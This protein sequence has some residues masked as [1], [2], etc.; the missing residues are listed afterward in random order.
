MSMQL[1]QYDSNL[2]GI[3]SPRAAFRRRGLR[4]YRDG[5]T[6]AWNPHGHARRGKLRRVYVI[7]QSMRQRCEDPNGRSYARYGGRGIKVCA[8][9]KRFENFLADMGEPPVGHTIERK[10]NNRGYSPSNCI[11]LPAAKQQWNTRKVR[12]LTHA[13]KTQPLEVW[14][15][16]LGM[17]SR[18]L[19]D[20]L[21][22]GWSVERALTQ[23]IDVRRRRK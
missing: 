2:W 23:P 3:L 10:N 12:L 9:W 20:R 15:R 1:R 13:G 14:E 5:S 22:R 17:G 18:T 6:R 4:R 8:R 19:H 16:E 21:A 11:W 7:W